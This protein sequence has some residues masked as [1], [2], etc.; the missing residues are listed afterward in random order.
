MKNA[1]DSVKSAFEALKQ[2]FIV[3]VVLAGIV[4]YP[5]AIGHTEVARGIPTGR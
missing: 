1:I 4:L 2:V 3:L 5:A